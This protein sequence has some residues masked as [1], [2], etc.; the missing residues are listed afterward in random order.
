M[1][2]SK[3]PPHELLMSGLIIN[4]H[5]PVFLFININSDLEID[6][7]IGI[8]EFLIFFWWVEFRIII[9]LPLPVFLCMIAE[10]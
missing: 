1:I 5:L 4:N 6:F 9:N 8:H 10:L 7:L 3:L 2:R